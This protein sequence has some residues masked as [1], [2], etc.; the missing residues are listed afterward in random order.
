MIWQEV[1]VGW[2]LPCPDQALAWAPQRPELCLLPFVPGSSNAH[3]SMNKGFWDLI[4]EKKEKKR[5]VW[6]LI[7]NLEKKII[8]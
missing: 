3:K 8:S 1:S 5:L 2:G 4:K 6:S 7:D